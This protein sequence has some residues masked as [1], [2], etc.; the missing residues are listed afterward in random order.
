LL[1]LLLNLNPPDVWVKDY[2]R[3]T[4]SSECIAGLFGGMTVPESIM[5]EWSSL[6]HLTTRDACIEVRDSA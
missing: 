4:P 3:G 6:R 1:I 2:H 5:N